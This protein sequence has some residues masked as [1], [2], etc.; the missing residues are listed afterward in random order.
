VKR[1]LR[2]SLFWRLYGMGFAAV[3]VVW[4]S[5]GVYTLIESR[6]AV[7]ER[8]VRDL[9]PLAESLATVTALDPKPDLAEA[10]GEALRTLQ[11][12]KS[13][14]PLVPS[15][16]LYRV[17]NSDGTLL[18]RSNDPLPANALTAETIP[19]GDCVE[20]A[21]WLLSAGTSPR[22][23][24][25][26]IFGESREYLA[27]VADVAAAKFVYPYLVFAVALAAVVWGAL[28]FG[29]LP[30]RQIAAAIA[31]RKA[32]NLNPLVPARE[33]VEIE[34]L[35][36]ALNG[37]FSRIHRMLELE[38]EFFADAAHELRTPLAVI[39]AQAHVAAH[40]MDAS[41]RLRAAAALDQGVTR[42]ARVLRRLM[43]LARL[44][45]A[46]TPLQTERIDTR[47]LIEDVAA[48]QASS[49][50]AADHCIHVRVEKS[51]SIL[52][53]LAELRTALDCLLDNAL[54]HTPP[55]TSVWIAAEIVGGEYVFSVSDDGPGIPVEF[56]ERAF[57]RFER[58]GAT[59]PDGSGLGLAIVRRV[60]ELHGGR[61]FLRQGPEGRGC[62]AEIRLPRDT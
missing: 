54:K 38:R 58:L 45:A 35:I 18:A 55:G 19:F 39:S 11:V 46:P 21:G 6:N 53:S 60:A 52:A 4:L 23:T 25:I 26:A 22:G 57:R 40:E 42:M 7:R 31:A 34:P 13:I 20:R 16:V 62:R 8:V 36:H 43:L 12:R 9:G 49:T 28:R 24:V 14:L 59:D 29:L 51:F 17:W 15:D 10:L 2:S 33:Y 3:T 56:Q 27:H 41:A 30:I 44:D 5:F 32:T 61:A 48:V 37:T 1:W 47:E 50:A